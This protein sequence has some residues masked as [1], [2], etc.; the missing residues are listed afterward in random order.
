MEFTETVAYDSVYI[1]G[2]AN[3]YEFDCGGNSGW[4]YCV[5]GF[6]PSYGCS[7]YEVKDGD[8]IE[9]KYTCNLGYDVGG[10]YAKNER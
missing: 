5:N 8:V 9:W 4:M 2:I 10:G 7:K 6:F 1:E 3:L